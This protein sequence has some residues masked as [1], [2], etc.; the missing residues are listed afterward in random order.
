MPRTA[1]TRER[2]V[3][4]SV[5]LIERDGADELSM[6]RVAAELG[7]GTMS[8]Y[9]HVPNKAALLDAVAEHIM[10]GMVYA[11]DPAVDWRDQ[12]RTLAR[13]FREVARRYPRSVQLVITRQPKSSVGLQSMEMALAAVRTAGFDDRT[14]VQ[15]VRT[16]VAFVLGSLINEVSVKERGAPPAEFASELERAHYTNVRA[17]LPILMVHDHDSDFEFGLELLISAMAALPRNTP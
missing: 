10:A 4:A 17:V 12:T 5:D 7:V 1:L 3:H 16:F 2:I 8:L 13:A 15:L 6:R 11:D 14:A 9:N